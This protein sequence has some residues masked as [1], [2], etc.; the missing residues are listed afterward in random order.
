MYIG[1]SG[2]KGILLAV[3]VILV[4]DHTAGGEGNLVG[5][6]IHFMVCVL[7]APLLALL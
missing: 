4:L 7:L 5:I 2:H 6:I 3:A 1:L